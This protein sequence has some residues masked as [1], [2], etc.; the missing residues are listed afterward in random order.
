MHWMPKLAVSRRRHSNI[1]KSHQH[2]PQQESQKPMHLPKQT[3]KHNKHPLQA[4]PPSP[5]TSRGILRSLSCAT[6]NV[7]RAPSSRSRR[8]KDSCLAALAISHVYLTPISPSPHSQPIH[9]STHPSSST[10]PASIYPAALTSTSILPYTAMAAATA[11]SSSACGSVTSNS[12]IEAPS[13]DS[14]ARR[15][16]ASPRAVAITLSPR[17]RAS[18]V[19][20]EPKPEVL[21]VI[22][23]VS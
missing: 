22:S 3:S 13:A 4:P 15:E 9:I 7:V 16:D 18:L 20:R 14:S 2:S 8:Q 21:P 10:I 5:L 6:G 17:E 23:Q 12:R 11:A 19:K 1:P